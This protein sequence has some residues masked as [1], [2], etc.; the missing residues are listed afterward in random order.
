MRI[1]HFL[2]AVVMLLLVADANA[3]RLEACLVDQDGKPVSGAV[4]TNGNKQVYSNA[5]GCFGIDTSGI[6]YLRINRTGFDPLKLEVTMLSDNQ[7]LMH[8]KDNTLNTF[9]VNGIVHPDTIVS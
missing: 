3:Q 8:R 9:E 5:Q 1:H 6:K 4:V 2:L 7:L